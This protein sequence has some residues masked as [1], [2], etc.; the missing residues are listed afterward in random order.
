MLYSFGKDTHSTPGAGS[1]K[2]VLG[3]L[4]AA[5]VFLFGFQPAYADPRYGGTLRL[6]QEIDASGFDA[7]KGRSLISAGR[8]AASLV[9]EKLFERRQDGGLVPILGLSAT[10][11]E[12]GKTWTVKLRQGIKFH[13][14][15]TFTADAVVSHWQ[16]ILDP[17]N[18][19]RHRL[20]LRPVTSVEKAGE[21]DV[22][23]HLK[24]AW[25]PFT[26]A[27]SNPGGFTAYIPSPAA[28][29][30][31]IQN[32][33]P[34]GTG[35]FIFKEWKTGDRIVV[36]KN[37]DY[38]Q[39]G[40]PYLDQ[41]VMRIIT[42]HESRY[43][44]LASGEVDVMVTDR[45]MHVKKLSNN[46]DFAKVVLKFRGAGILAMNN[47]KPPLDDRRVRRALALAWDQKKYI[48]ASFKDILPYTETWL[49]DMLDCGDVNYPKPDVKKARALIAEYGNPVTLEYIHS[50]TN[51]GREAGIILQQMMKPIGVEIKP[52][53]LDF[54]G[55]M[56]QLFS[57]RYDISSWVIPGAYDM[58]PITVAQ[59]HSRS[60]WNVSGYASKAVDALLLE[61]QTTTDPD[62]RAQTM[63]A[64]A[65]KVNADIPYL[66]LFGRQY[67]LFARKHVRNLPQP[68]PGV[69]GGLL[70]DV[71]LDK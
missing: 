60:P 35:P 63:C 57:K 61:L 48:K 26:D 17:K 28:V 65:R 5:A 4:L 52:V 8:R 6:A 34:V 69:E 53:P 20:L 45:P 37:P 1:G 66:Y 11:S 40:K 46:P 30:K 67:Y 24:H 42:D 71:W 15:T 19:Y 12:D 36:S 51:R 29:E 23:F 32:R 3:T 25:L 68:V 9:M 27:L 56:K 55:I 43:A 58:G 59:L 13:D 64:I 50:A 14:G 10:A 39:T 21:Y 2:M 22:R 62:A 38:W 7:I 33:S 16:R 18:R 49:G 70:S 44:A 31:G 41:V 47:T 54:P